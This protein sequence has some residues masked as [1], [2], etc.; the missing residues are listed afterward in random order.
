[1]ATSRTAKDMCKD[2]IDGLI[3]ADDL[4]VDQVN[5]M[6]DAINPYFSILCDDSWAALSI[7]PHKEDRMKKI[8][9]TAL[10]SFLFGIAR[11]YE[12]EIDPSSKGHVTGFLKHNFLYDPSRHVRSA[13]S[14]PDSDPERKSRAAALD[15]LKAS[16]VAPMPDL[17]ILQGTYQ[18]LRRAEL[19][20]K[21]AAVTLPVGGTERLKIETE[22]IAIGLEVEKVAKFVDASLAKN[23]SMAYRVDPPADLFYNLNRYI[24]NN[25]EGIIAV[26]NDV[27]NEK[28]DID[29]SICYYDSFRSEADALDFTKINADN[30]KIPA[31]V[32]QNNSITMLGPYKS[33]VDK[34]SFY[35]SNTAILEKL[36]NQAELDAKLGKDL[37]EKRKTIK[38][39]RNIRETGPDALGLT[40]YVK[41]SGVIETLGSARDPIGAD[42][43]RRIFEEDPDMPKDSV[44]VDVHTVNVDEEGNS[45]MKSSKFYS[46]AEAPLHLDDPKYGDKYQAKKQ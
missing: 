5:E 38:K 17:S 31:Y 30:F 42:E 32:V 14:D 19:A 13:Q 44:R 23:T 1:M 26:V 18:S 22:V 27:Y 40:S 9:V 15:E 20:L 46:Q 10:I 24:D 21:A 43:Q 37:M 33:N 11:E 2:L 6:K 29:Y 25:Y 36:M 39:R 7:I 35:N 4:T 41:D 16:E 34:V 12:R 8:V 3:N 45:S 28:S